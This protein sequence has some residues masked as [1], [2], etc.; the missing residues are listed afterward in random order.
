MN[1]LSA[2]V[3][4]LITLTPGPI[5]RRLLRWVFGWEIHASANLGASLFYNVSRVR[6]G[7]GARIGHLNVF[8]NLRSIELG[9]N[10]SI[11]QWNWITAAT[12]LV[13]PPYAP[14]SG[15][16]RI[17]DEAAITSRHYIDCA[18]GIEIGTATT[19]AGVRSTILSHQIDVADSRQ[20]AVPVR[21]G[22]Y[23]FVGSNVLVTPGASIPDR[24]VI[25]MGATVVGRLPN[26]GTLY[27]GVP[28]KAL[29]TVDEGAYFARERG[30]VGR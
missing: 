2:M 16:I 20:T 25:A 28:A 6:M 27:G 7:P 8:R 11:G 3:I 26:R 19:I 10:A 24:C 17:E 23:C 14:T 1:R 9:S 22:A 15:C 18:G 30:F 5:K 13:D 4:A 21:I 29:K 12:M